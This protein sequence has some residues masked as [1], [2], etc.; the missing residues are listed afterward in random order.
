VKTALKFLLILAVAVAVIF[1]IVWW[2]ASVLG[3]SQREACER[4]GARPVKTG[5]GHFLCVAPDGRVVG[6]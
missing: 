6:P 1:G 5:H 3:D 4:L 2:G